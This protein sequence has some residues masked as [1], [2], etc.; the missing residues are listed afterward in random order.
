M[1]SYLTVGIDNIS[2]ALF[3]SVKRG[4]D[5]KKASGGLWLTKYQPIGNPWLEYISDKPYLLIYKG[6]KDLTRIPCSL[7]TLKDQTNLF[8]LDSDA[9]LDYL[10]KHYGN[11]EF[12][13]YPLLSQDYDG[14][15]ID[16]SKNKNHP[17]LDKL[18]PSF[19]LDSLILFNLNCISYYQEGEIHPLGF[20]DEFCFEDYEIVISPE[21]KEIIPV[22]PEYQLLAEQVTTYV[23]AFLQTKGLTSL[24]PEAYAKLVHEIYDVVTAHLS[25]SLEDVAGKE[26]VN[27]RS[28][29]YTLIDNAINLV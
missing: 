20:Y 7:V 19:C 21:Q 24:S 1:A 18:Y 14:I 28:L 9:K 23:N 22:S 12:F 29:T 16:F 5:I 11:A 26:K 4:T 2:G 15:Y 3:R 25:T 17:K 6:I 27:T 8:I 10:M 13:S